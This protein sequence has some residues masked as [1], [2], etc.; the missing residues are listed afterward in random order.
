MRTPHGYVHMSD[1]ALDHAL[2]RD[3]VAAFADGELPESE[4]RV[5]EDHLYAC[6]PCRREL[7]L[8]EALS[9]AL[10]PE[11]VPAASQRLRRRIEQIGM[12]TLLPAALPWRTWAAPAMATAMVAAAVV[13]VAAFVSAGVGRASSLIARGEETNAVATVALLRDAVN[14]CNRVMTRNFPRKADLENVRAGLAFPVQVLGQ[15]DA[16]LFS[17]WKTTL[18]GAPAVGLAYRW[19]GLVVVQYAVSADALQQQPELAEALRSGSF[20]SASEHGQGIVASVAHGGGTLLV[21]NAP[22]AELRRLIL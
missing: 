9:S 17:T 15:P 21:A 12:P 20:Y 1:A 6:A 10:A 16:R 22:P 14:D 8:Q 18:A 7:A 4:A 19:R 13:G 2:L 3:L 11:A 5:V